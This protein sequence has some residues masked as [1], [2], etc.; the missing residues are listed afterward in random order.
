MFSVPTLPL[1]LR[2]DVEA[3]AAEIS[4]ELLSAD[5]QPESASDL[6]QL[7]VTGHVADE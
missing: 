5:F 4:T 6:P 1:V 3:A 2:P 7:N